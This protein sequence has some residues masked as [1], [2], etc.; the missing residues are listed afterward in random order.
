MVLGEPRSPQPPRAEPGAVGEADPPRPFPRTV[1]ALRPEQEITPTRDGR[2]DGTVALLRVARAERGERLHR[3]RRA[4]DVR[5][6]DHDVGE[7][8]RSVQPLEPRGT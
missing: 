5:R 6:I 3:G 8:V 4:L 1:V 2:G 7:A